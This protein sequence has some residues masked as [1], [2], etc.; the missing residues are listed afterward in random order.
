LLEALR[1]RVKDIDFAASLLIVRQGKGAKDRRTIL[2]ESVKQ[3]LRLQIEDARRLHQRDLARGLGEVALPHALDRKYRNAAKELAWQYVF[4]S[5][6]LW[7][8]PE[9]GVRRRHHLDESVI[10]KAFKQAVR[11]AQIEKHAVCHTPRHCAA[12]GISGIALRPTFSRTA[13]TSEPFRSCSG[14]LT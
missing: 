1:L 5:S 2:P 12:P 7:V 4:P 14:T 10:Q 11:T 8:D 9:S 6:T 13:T 3:P